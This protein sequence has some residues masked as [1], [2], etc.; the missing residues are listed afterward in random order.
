MRIGLASY[1]FVNNDVDHNLAQMEAALRL[2]QG[3][4]EL[5]CF[6]E[7]FLQGFDAL[8]WNYA[9][10]KHI[11]LPIDSAPMRHAALSLIHI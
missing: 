8:R 6:G 10:D 3:K 4:V 2:A 7:A 9:D 1:P 11:A 5:L